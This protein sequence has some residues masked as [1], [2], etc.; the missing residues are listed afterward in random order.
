M[1][2]PYKLFIN[3]HS[4]TFERNPVL[5]N[6]S[7]EFTRNFGILQLSEKSNTK[8]T[9]IFKQNVWKLAPVYPT[10]FRWNLNIL[11]NF[12]PPYWIR[13]FLP[14]KIRYHIWIKR[15]E[16]F[17]IMLKFNHFQSFKHR[18]RYAIFN[19]EHLI[20]NFRFKD[21]RKMELPIF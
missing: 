3:K 12:N 13:L 18:F 9:K 16:N 6:C 20:L 7:Q 21:L 5:F 10:H 15:L 1:T 8:N 19:F 14:W 11:L 4:V 17:K 2:S